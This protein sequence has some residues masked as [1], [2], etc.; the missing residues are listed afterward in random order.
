M[1][2]LPAPV[3]RAAGVEEQEA[4]LVL[5]KG[6]VRVAED[7]YASLRESSPEASATALLAPGV[8]NHGYLSAAKVELQR[9]GQVHFRQVHV[10][11][12]GADGGVEGELV[13]HKRLD[14]IPRVQHE[15]ST[16]QVIQQAVWKCFRA[17]RDVGISKNDS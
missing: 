15:V 8:V 11:R 10:A 2:W 12:H 3:G 7:Y 14:Q 4:I 17:T 9:L 6:D 16:F 13:E 5:Q 1:V